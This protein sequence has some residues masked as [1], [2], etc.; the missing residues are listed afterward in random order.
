MYR[1]P[2]ILLLLPLFLTD[3]I[4]LAA[5]LL[6]ISRLSNQRFG[7]T[8]FIMQNIFYLWELLLKPSIFLSIIIYEC[9]SYNEN[10]NQRENS[11]RTQDIM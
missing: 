1:T 4:L 7:W 6:K 9:Y 8:I 11:F 2:L 10:A 3:K 5:L